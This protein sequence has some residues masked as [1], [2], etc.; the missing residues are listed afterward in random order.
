MTGGGHTMGRKERTNDVGQ[1]RG[2]HTVGA[3]RV[4]GGDRL[5]LYPWNEIRAKPLREKLLTSAINYSPLLV[6][7]W[8]ARMATSSVHRAVPWSSVQGTR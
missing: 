7:A 6:I 8:S 2:C 5:D 3:A 1:S 4:F